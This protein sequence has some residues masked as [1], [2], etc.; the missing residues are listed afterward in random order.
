ME[1]ELPQSYQLQFH[2]IVKFK[3]YMLFLKFWTHF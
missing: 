2:S 1:I 3:S